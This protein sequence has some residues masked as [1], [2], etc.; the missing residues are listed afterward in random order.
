MLVRTIA[1]IGTSLATPVSLRHRSKTFVHTTALS[2]QGY[3]QTGA[4][5]SL[6]GLPAPAKA[7]AVTCIGEFLAR[8][9][10]F[11]S[12]TRITPQRSKLRPPRAQTRPR[13]VHEYN[14]TTDLHSAA[15]QD[16]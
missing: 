6:P 12:S 1:L 16:Q 5:L 14:Q 4:Q 10:H 8:Y 15:F 3:A 9:A 13:D 2:L 11:L 7:H